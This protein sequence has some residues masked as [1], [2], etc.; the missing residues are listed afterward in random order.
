MIH[1]H[2]PMSNAKPPLLPLSDMR[3]LLRWYRLNL[4]DTGLR[5]PRGH[6][7]QYPT[8]AL[9]TYQYTGGSNGIDCNDGSTAGLIVS[10]P[11]GTWTYTRNASYTTTTVV[12]PAGNTTV[13][14]F[15]Q[16]LYDPKPSFL[17]QMQV[18][19]GS[20]TLLATTVYCYNGNQTSCVTT[21]PTYPITQKDAYTTLAGMSVSNRVSEQYDAYGNTTL[22]AFYDFGATT[23]T[24][25]TVAGPY[26]YTWNG[27]TTSPTCTTPIGSGVNNKP[28]Q[29]Q[30]ENGSGGQLRNTYFQYGT[31]TYPGSLLST[32]VLTGGSTYLTT[33]A[34]YNA[35]GTVATTTDANGHVTTYTQGACNSGFV[36]KIVPPIS[37]L[38][39]QYTWDSGCNGAKMMSATDP[40]GF[41]VSATYNDPFWRP[42]SKSDQLNN[43]VNLSYYPTV[44]INTTEAQMTSGSSD[45]DVF[46]TADTLGRPV[47]TQQIEGPG[48]SWDTTQMGY[49]WSTTGRVTTK[50]MPCPTS[51][52]SGCSNGITTTA[53]DAL[54][55]PLLITDGGGG[56]ITN[57]Y[58]MQD[59][60]TVLGPAPA[61]EVVKQVQK[62]YNGLG[63]LLSVCQLSS[64]AGTTS[65]G[66]V[67]GET[68]YLTTYNYN[69]DGTVA[70]VVRGTQTHSFTYDAMGRTLTATYPESGTK[71]LYYD[72]AP[73]TPGVA[74]SSTAL[75]TNSSPLGNLVKTYDANGTTTCFSYD[76]MNRRTS[77]AYAGTNWDGENKYFTYDSATVNS[78]TMTNTLGR[79]AEA[80]TAPASGGTKV[81]DEGFSYTARGEVSDVYQ[82]T[83]NSGGYYDTN[84]TYFANH[85]LN[86]LSGVTGGP[87][88]YALD[89]KGRPYSAIQ[90]ASTKIV[91]STTYNAADEP[92]VVTLGLGD[93]DSYNYDNNATRSGLLTTARMTSYSFSVGATPTTD[94]GSLTWN[95]NG[96]LRALAITDGFNTGGTHGCSYGTSST[97]GYDELG[98]LVS[99]VCTNSSGTNVWGQSFSY[100]AFDNLTKTVPGGATGVTWAPGYNQANNEYLGGGTDCNGAT[101]CYDL[102][103]N[104]LKDTFH[105]YTWN[106]D[107]HPLTVT[108]GTS[109]IR[110]L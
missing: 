80:Y 18:Y 92:C 24:R 27:S 25:Q 82:S 41:S 37:T 62:E 93:S 64:A 100:D 12:N 57:T 97:P 109:G 83:P 79:I 73:S 21:L 10:T 71:Y 20:G 13:Y 55:C 19:Q 11:D 70:S 77:I 39:T 31:T 5:D 52:G 38:D 22:K 51:K 108:G 86:T 30:V 78:T 59:V 66:Q 4:C 98:R 89:G 96:A 103:G 99:A 85:A 2:A 48:G 32:A 81:T 60:L 36:T 107:N 35:N 49:S 106:Q 7:I 17:T 105:T 54:G 33:S 47:L 63:Q 45:F 102:N 9:H 23:P 67:N 94:V 88:T 6:R 101:I 29:V 104:L 34:T 42:T 90:G 26:G 95:A 28:C 44:P 3:E 43:T 69:A 61:G 75:L 50:T 91:T 72:S 40:N 110:G 87:W 53:Y 16:G 15:A 1:P 68:G 58:T 56:T 8:G 14:T 65:C 74:C 76:T 84:A 46:N